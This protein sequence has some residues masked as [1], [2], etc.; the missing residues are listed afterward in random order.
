MGEAKVGA[1]LQFP[2]MRLRA[3]ELAALE[4]G[5]ILRLPLPKHSTAELRVGGMLLATAHPVRTGEHRGAQLEGAMA[6]VAGDLNLNQQLDE[7]A[8]SGTMSVN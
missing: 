5:T 1:L 2:R 6:N 7:H 3:S 4:K 8:M